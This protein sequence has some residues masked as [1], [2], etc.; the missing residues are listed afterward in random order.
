MNLQLKDKVAIVTGSSK[1]IGAGIAKAFA[2]AGAKVV[3]NYAQNQ[4]RAKKVVEEIINFGGNAIA[5][6]ANVSKSDDVKRLFDETITAFERI[7]ILV[8]NAGIYDIV[9]LEDITTEVL[10]A[11]L[12]TNLIG[13]ILCTKKAASL[14]D[15]S[16]GSIINISS[17][18]S[19]NPMPGTLIYA[20]TKA[21]VDNVTK[22]LAKELGPKKIRVNTISPGITETEGSHEKGFMGGEW[23]AQLLAQVPLGRIGQPTDIAKVAVFLASDDAGWVTGERIQV[24]GGQL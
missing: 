15:S 19:T 8:N 9:L 18:V 3:V 1:G 24:A 20:A 22:V 7:D 13:T 5:I 23:E 12:D 11:N 6:Q 2:M 14:M 16:G 17:T 21:A 4:V 10:Q